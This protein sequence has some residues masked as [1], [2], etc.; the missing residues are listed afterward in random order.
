MWSRERL[1]GVEEVLVVDLH[2][3]HGDRGTYTLLSHVPVDHPDD[4]WLRRV[5]DADR[6]EC[7]S[8]SV[9]GSAEGSVD[10]SADRDADATTGSKHGQIAT[11]LASVVPDAAWRTVTMELGTI[12][13]TRMIL[14]ERA[15]HWVHVHGD[16][17]DPDHARIVWD[18]RC[19]STPDDPDWERSARAHGAVVLDAARDPLCRHVSSPN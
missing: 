9:D 6:I 10:G 8:S 18:H 17:S 13:D 7:T 15:E 3:G 14:N 2:T 5:F 12:S 16:R 4:A 1:A 19:G 11:G